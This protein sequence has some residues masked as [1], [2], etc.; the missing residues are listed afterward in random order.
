MLC[1]Y[2]KH[3]HGLGEICTLDPINYVEPE[4]IDVPVVEGT[5][6]VVLYLGSEGDR[7]E[8]IQALMEIYPNMKSRKL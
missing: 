2:C 4:M 7:E 5:F 1:Q 6:P 8:L 3:S